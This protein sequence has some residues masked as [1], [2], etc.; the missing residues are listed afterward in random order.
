MR[1]VNLVRAALTAALL[2]ALTLMTAPAGAGGPT[3]ALL[4]VPGAGSTASLY[5]TDPEY[6][7]LAGLV[8]VN[9]P[10]GTFEGTE[11]GGHEY[12]PGVTV[13]WLVHDVE[14][15]RVDRIY[16][17]GKGGPWISTQVSDFSGGSIWESPVLWHR[18]ANGARLTALL[19]DLGLETAAS[20]NADVEGVAGAS[21]QDTTVAP[22][23]AT[24]D[25]AAAPEPGWL[26][27]VGWT[28]G[29][30]VGGALL[31]FAWTRRRVVEQA[32]PIRSLDGSAEVLSR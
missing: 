32:E 19:D 29:G 31:M 25:P 11:S 30:L 28:L 27:R 14:P 21:E 26:G 8:G 16:V 5:Y 13:T 18:P 3:S 20:E 23:L 24:P 2:S 6:D 15:W 1:R 10:S 22:T 17:G 9:E 12:G 7:E 4:S